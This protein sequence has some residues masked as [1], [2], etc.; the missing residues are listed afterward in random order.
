LVHLPLLESLTYALSFSRKEFFYKQVASNS[1]FG[2][3]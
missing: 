1:F 2:Y 3:L